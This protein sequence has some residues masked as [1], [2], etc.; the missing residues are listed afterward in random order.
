M[1]LDLWLLGY[2]T[3]LNRLVFTTTFDWLEFNT[4]PNWLGF[5]LQR[6]YLG[7]LKFLFNYTFWRT[8]DLLISSNLFIRNLFY[9]ILLARSN[10]LLSF[11]PETFWNN[12]WMLVNMWSWLHNHGEMDFQQQEQYCT[13]NVRKV[14]RYH[15]SSH[16]ILCRD[17]F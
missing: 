17:D 5:C 6:G 14:T 7:Y 16:I 15:F 8:V 12:F 11:P 13:N 9:F 1:Q 2:N 4:I 10:I 3:I